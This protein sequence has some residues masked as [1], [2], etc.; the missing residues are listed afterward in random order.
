MAGQNP[1]RIYHARPPSQVSFKYLRDPVGDSIEMAV[2]GSATAVNFDYTVPAGK[3]F[4][5]HF[6]NMLVIDGAAEAAGF[7]GL[8]PLTTGLSLVVVGVNGDTLFDF[9]GEATIKR[10][11]H[12]GAFAGAERTLDDKGAGDD[13]ITLHL[14]LEQGSQVLD[15]PPGSTIR[16][17]VNDDLSALTEFR[18]T[19]QGSLVSA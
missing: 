18:M 13:V 14:N 5:L 9:T 19:V 4:L 16:C 11:V 17:T 6:V 8:S 10:T 1:T 12:F 2:N 7:G 15:M 3:R